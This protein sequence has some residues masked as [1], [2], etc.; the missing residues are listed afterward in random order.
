[1]STQP[2]RNIRHVAWHRRIS[3]RATLIALTVVLSVGVIGLCA[4]LLWTAVENSARAARIQRVNTAADFLLDAAENW[5]AERGLMLAAL[6]AP[7]AADAGT[8]QAIVRSRAE[9][10][11]AYGEAKS[12]LEKVENFTGKAEAIAAA[13]AAHVRVQ[14]L[15]VAADAAAARALAGRDAGVLRDWTP[16]MTDLIVRSQDVRARA[17]RVASDL[18]GLVATLLTIKHYS[19]VLAEYAGRERALIAGAIGAGRPLSQDEVL[20]DANIRGTIDLARSRIASLAASDTTPAAIKDALAKAEQAYFGTFE[21]LRGDVLAASANG[22][23]YPVSGAEWFRAAT[24]GVSALTGVADAGSVSARA[25]ADATSS[26]ATVGIVIAAAVMAIGLAVAALGYWVASARVSKPIG[27]ITASMSRISSGEMQT[28]VPYLDRLDEI[29]AMAQALD[30]FKRNMLEADR[31]RTEQEKLKLEQEQA[32]VRAEQ[33]KKA[34][35]RKLADDFEASISGVVNTVSSAAT[36]LQT[37]AQA[38]SATAEQTN[39]Q[40]SA[41]A[42]ASEQASANVQTVATA[43]EELSAS[44]SEIGR[45][46]GQSS[47]ITQDAVAQAGQTNDKIRTLAEAAQSIGDVVKLISDIAGQTNLLALNATI[48]AARAGEAGKG[49]A[50][51]ASEV[52][53][54][55]NQTAKAT[56]EISAKIAEMQNATGESVQAIQTITE[57]I[58]RINEIATTIASAIEEQ[59]AATQEIARNVQQAAKGTQEVSNNISG[60]TQAATETGSAATQVL[61][62]AGELAQQGEVLRSKVDQFIATVRAA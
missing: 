37:T 30:I 21:R 15:R 27:G 11:K 23:A 39:Q 26:R 12:A 50:V 55:A 61:S 60:V 56:E 58:G 45:Q 43:G 7:E 33:E 18:E 49:F 4:N 42:A 32:K 46:V 24:D 57:T 47:R 40:A 52:K 19:W 31:L 20:R 62:S 22:A 17:A 14:M 29:G 6:N 36:E 44:I 59:G 41:V 53:S 25:Y 10:E 48:E 54:L 8:Q 9:A 13:E 5:A 16:A 51:V 35:M 38:M 34:A 1:M 2:A 3:I 28:E